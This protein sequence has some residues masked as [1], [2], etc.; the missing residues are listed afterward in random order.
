MKIAVVG[1]GN[2]GR[3]LVRAFHEL[4]A[5]AAVVD[6]NPERLQ[7]VGESY[8]EVPCFPNL[9]AMLEKTDIRGVVVAAPAEAHYEL[10]R[11]ALLAGKDVFVEKPLA[12]SVSHA[13]ELVGL[14]GQLERVLMVGHLALYQPAAR[15]VKECL[16]SGRL[17]RIH[18]IHAERLKLGRVRQVED[19]LWSF[20]VHDVALLVYLLGGEPEEAEARG[21]AVLQPAIAD[22]VYLHL[23]FPGGVRGHVHVSWLW[24]E[25]RRRLTIVGSE[26]MLVYDEMEGNAVLHHKRVDPGLVACDGGSEVVF[27]GGGE[28][29]LLECRDFLDAL[30]R[31]SVP[32]ASG[33]QGVAVVKVLQRA[34]QSLSGVRGDAANLVP[35]DAYFVHPSSFVDPS[36]RVG[37]GTKVWHFCHV[38]AGAEIGEDCSLGQ[39]VFVGRNVRVGNRVKVQNN[40]SLYEGVVLE[41][42]VFCGPS[43]VFTNVK[44]PRAAYPRNTSGHY[45][46]TLVKRGATIGAN[47]TVVCGATIGEWAFVAAGAVVTRDVSPYAV[48]AGVPARVVGWACECGAPLA[49]DDAEGAC[50]ECGRRYIRNG[51]GVRPVGRSGGDR[52]TDLRPEARG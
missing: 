22:D 11:Q 41:D 40:V 31:R 52:D 33:T 13:E 47:A 24:P 3:N 8:P 38:M 2:W 48:A 23:E 42:D 7:E 27:R 1:A 9:G 16:E 29:L 39:N 36:A 10:A 34:M 18:S 20:A 51:G 17:G 32:V 28:P 37:R 4:G 43:A 6:A 21:Q 44:T 12:L 49:L 14:A 45:L 35:K 25:Q 26:A 15:C 46:R 50:R 19:V 5:L 30:A